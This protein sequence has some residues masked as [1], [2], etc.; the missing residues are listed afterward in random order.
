MAEGRRHQVPVLC[1]NFAE[2][3]PAIVVPW[4]VVDD[5]R[6]L[7][8][9]GLASPSASMGLTAAAGTWA[10]CGA[11]FGYMLYDCAVMLIWQ[12]QM[13][14]SMGSGLYATI[15]GHHLL[16][17]GCWAIALSRR[18]CALMVA[19]FLFSEASNV[20]LTARTILIKLEVGGALNTGVSVVFI[21]LFFLIR[22]L[23]LPMLAYLLFSGIPGLTHL[24]GFERFISWT[25]GPLPLLLN[26][27]WFRLAVAG[28]LKFMRK[29]PAKEQKTQ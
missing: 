22:I 3:V 6:R 16:S 23:P 19:W 12:R 25:T 27:H 21:V 5:V 20:F 18:N 1:K 11:I 4:L 14:K 13:H 15:W 29:A 24:T 10:S 17:L 7:T 26:L 2:W 8:A 28:L 9:E